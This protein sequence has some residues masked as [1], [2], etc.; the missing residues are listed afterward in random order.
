M[1]TATR[2]EAMTIG[3]VA[4]RAGVKA[5]TIRYYEQIGVLP[6]P[7]RSSGQ[8]RYGV[9]VLR[10][11]AI[12]GVAQRA[13]FSLDEVA[14]LLATGDG[15][16]PAHETIQALAE[17]KLPEMDALIERAQAVRGWLELA[18]ACQ[19]STLDACALFDDRALE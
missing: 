14:Q 13:G 5:S 11:L 12:V 8:R 9:D 2:D 3:Q 6:E 15:H 1:S 4:A 16:G 17:R 7:A 10:R 18:R 19:C